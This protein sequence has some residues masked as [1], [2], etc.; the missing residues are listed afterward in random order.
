MISTRSIGM[1]TIPTLP[2]KLLLHS[3]PQKVVNRIFLILLV[4]FV[5]FCGHEQIKPKSCQYTN[6]LF[7]KIQQDVKY[8]RYVRNDEGAE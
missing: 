4:V 1:V 6:K 3:W 2:W 7:K 8:P 5:V